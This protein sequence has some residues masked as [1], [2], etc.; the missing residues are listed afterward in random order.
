MEFHEIFNFSEILFVFF[1]LFENKVKNLNE[2]CYI[3]RGTPFVLCKGISSSVS[4]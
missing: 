2:W 1:P 4:F 3:R